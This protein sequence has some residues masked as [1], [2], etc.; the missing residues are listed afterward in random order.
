MAKR[1][2]SLPLFDLG[3]WEGPLVLPP[4]LT[5]RQRRTAEKLQRISLGLH[6]LTGLPL[7]GDA[8]KD[9]N[10]TKRK[11]QF[12]TCG[13]CVHLSRIPNEVRSNLDCGLSTHTGGARRWWPACV[14]Y[15]PQ[16]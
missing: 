12:G 7:Y 15:K 5:A 9:T 10:R 14:Q 11:P 1:V 6:P 8:P 4:G 16:D 2:D 3:E 13:T